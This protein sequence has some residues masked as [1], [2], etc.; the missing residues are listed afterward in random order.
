MRQ[1]MRGGVMVRVS[2]AALVLGM[3]GGA[4]AAQTVE[5]C[6]LV[7][8]VLPAGCAHADAGT[9]VPRPAAPSAG[10]DAAGDLGDLGFS[11]SI[12]AVPAAGPD[13]PR[14]TIAGAPAPRRDDLR[15]VDRGL[16]AMGL[17][18]TFDGLGA[19][20]ILNVSTAD[21]RRA[22]APGETLRFR[23]SSNYPAWI[24]RAEIVV[25]DADRP[26]A[27]VAVL[28]VAPNGTA[29]WTMPGDAPERMTYV[30]R[31]HDAAGRRDET[32]ALPLDRS[33]GG[34]AEPVFDGPL[35]AP[36]EGEDRTARRQIPVRGGA[37]TVSGED[38]P[39]GARLTVMGE[40][41]IPDLRRR[42]VIQR[43]LPPGDHTV[44]LALGGRTETRA[45]T[46]PAR[47]FFSTGIVDLTLG[48]D[49]VARETWRFGR[50]AGFARG[51][52]AD[53]TRITASV[54]TR[55]A[56]LRDLFRNFARKHPDQ[57]LRQIE[58]RDVWVTTGDDS[59]R[60]DLAPTSGRFYLRAEKDGSH[61]MWGDFKPDSDLS[62]VVR[63]DRTLYGAQ[64]TWR[65]RA[66]TPEGE[67]RA[68]VSA[69]A[70]E[71]DSLAQ[72]DVF[73]ATGGSTYFLSRR[74]IETD[75][76]TVTV[77]V[78]DPVSGRLV[79]TRRLV[80]GQDYRIDPV[81]G[82]VILNA[83]LSPATEGPGLVT[84]RPLGDRVVNLV[85]QYEYV[86]ATGSIDGISA[87]VRAEV[88]VTPA[89]RFGVSGATETTGLAD[90]RLLG[91]DL[92]WRRSEGTY[93]SF[94]LAQSEGPGFGQSL[95]LTG[96]LDIDP[97]LPDAGISGQR[98]TGTR[99]EGRLDLAELG[100]RGYIAG[101]FDRRGEGFSSPDYQVDV[102]QRTGGIE[103]RVGIG[104]AT[105][106]TFGADLFR[107]ANGKRDDRARIGFDHAISARWRIEGELAH[108]DRADPAGTLARDTGTRSDAG[109]RLTWTR[110][111]DLSVWVFGQGTLDR[112]GGIERN[113]RLGV[114]A[115][116]RI[117]DGL[118]ARGEISGG[119]L[120]AAA[121]AELAW[122]PNADATYTLGYSLD[123]LRALET[124][125]VTGRDRGSLTFGAQRR[126]SDRW[127]YTAENAWSRLEDRPSLTSAYGVSYTPSERWR[128]DAGLVW[129]TGRETDG[130]EVDRRGLSL[131]LRH[132]AGEDLTARLRG[133]W[134][135]DTSSNPARLND[136]T[137]WLVSGAF[138]R[139]TSEDWRLE[140][141]LDAVISEADGDAL[142]DGRYI[143]ARLGYAYRPVENDR[144][145]ALVSYTYLQDL[146]GADQVNIDGDVEGPR[147]TSH[148][149]N[150]ALSYDL[151]Q[152]LTLGA[153]Y[154][155]RWREATD[156]G[157]AVSTRSVAHLGVM[158]LDYRVVHRWDI[159][160]ELR[161]LHVPRLDTTEL[162]ALL[163]VYREVSPNL[164]L[165]AGYS[166]GA[167][168]DDLRRVEPARRGLFVNIIGKF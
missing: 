158:R 167:V 166:W 38:L 155:L 128:Y 79:E 21:M 40:P 100:G 99:I 117:T 78:R 29:S 160:G 133:E 33:A 125:G 77:E 144:L 2:A 93:L 22:Y 110:D 47:E 61:V 116:A 74:D 13:A 90:N 137:T 35:T 121:R 7:D 104:A 41:V 12:D 165:G 135:R 153:K 50:I 83:P 122:A 58:D 106:L 60:E 108:L 94:D 163:G 141:S 24:A 123:P 145:N 72:R 168:S 147:Q 87:G 10:Q 37:I 126:V 16:D 44:T 85:V 161:A 27:P 34:L 157:A 81:Q 20:P 71:P 48:R 52:L 42:F 120:G 134:R 148:I 69:Y 68:T 124:P 49:H 32:Q 115:E 114:G 14:R 164:R 88:W 23:A 142:R 62:R 28:P 82:V 97:A 64:G 17:Q 15:A 51:V 138:S 103:G 26:G 57:V 56:E 73:R 8:G 3:T 151:S 139:R 146:P 89:L 30:L 130:T 46:I 119:N 53:G 59:T 5:G 36:G 143:E 76:E 102:A 112:S 95:S 156:R 101:Y 162:G 149:L 91:A 105:D 45:V 86:P 96:G 92:L 4:V 98:A 136:R 131:G 67:A 31:V 70:S 75:T 152:R 113:N 127:S 132:A 111:A 118:R 1:G 6:R 43:I 66:T 154:G 19:K 39:P 80:E 11:I 25:R 107:D 159:L 109:L 65:S 18:V 63:T 55:E 9:V 54:D 129:G 140:G 84:D 150:A